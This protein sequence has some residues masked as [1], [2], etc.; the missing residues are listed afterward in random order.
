LSTTNTWTGIN[1]F[2]SNLG[3]TS[4]SLSN[5]PLQV[6]STGTN[7]AFMSF[8]RGGSY[9]VNMG[10]D[11]DNVLRIGGWSASANRLQLDMSGNLTLAGGVFTTVLSTGATATSGTVTG[12][13]TLGA[14]STWQATFAD[15]AEYYPSDEEYEPG[16]VLVFGGESEVTM[17]TT[18]NDRKLAGVVSTHP[19]YIMNAGCEGTRVCM[20]LQGRVPVK[21]IGTVERGDMLVSSNVAGYAM[22]NNEPTYGCVIGKAIESKT[23][24]EPGLILVSIN[25]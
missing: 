13:W 19:A 1:Y 21:V 12:Q 5:P 2:Q 8:H 16:T 3:T 23:S 7:S 6:Y 22:V 24:E 20:A 25:I 9:A 14:G 4:G 17:S 18:A 11:S 15:L 10:L